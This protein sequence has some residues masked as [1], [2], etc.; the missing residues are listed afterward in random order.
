MVKIAGLNR[1]QATT[2]I[3]D[4]LKEYV[5]NP[6]INIRTVNFRITVLGDVNRPGVFIIKNDRITILEALGLA[7]DI[8]IQAERKNVLVIRE[9]NG[10][11]TYNRID[12]TSKSVFNSPVYYLTQN[13]VIYVAPNNSR[14]RSSTVG[15]S[16]SATLSVISIL[17]TAVAVAVSILR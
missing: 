10:K 14:I 11:T 12:L 9:A 17:V 15:P 8:S 3:T 13:D 2:L 5:K 16:T 1:N 7:G 6:I 4:L